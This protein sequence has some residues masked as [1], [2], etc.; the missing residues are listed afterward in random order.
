MS[1]ES[2]KHKPEV[3]HDLA[4]PDR[5]KAVLDGAILGNQGLWG[6]LV[7]PLYQDAPKWLQWLVYGLIIPSQLVV[8]GWLVYKTNHLS[9]VTVESYQPATEGRHQVYALNIPTNVKFAGEAVPL[10]DISVF[11]RFD[12]ELTLNIYWQAN[13]AL[14]IKRC[15]RWFPIITPIIRSQGV[16]ED[17][18][19]VAAIESMFENR[20]SPAG[21]GG[22]WQLMGSAANQYGLE[23]NREVDERF[24]LQKA[25]VAAC[26]YIK[27]ARRTLGSWS[28]ALASYNLGMGRI[29]RTM[30]RQQKESYYDLL[31]NAESS[32]YVFKVLA[33]KQIYLNQD[34][35]S[36]FI[37]RSE[38]LSPY[39]LKYVK[40]TS[41]IPDLSQWA[42]SKGINFEILKFYNPWLRANSLTVNGGKSYSI[43]LPK[44]PVSFKSDLFEPPVML[45]DSLQSDSSASDRL[46]EDDPNLLDATPVI[47]KEQ[48]ATPKHQEKPE[49][50]E[51]EFMAQQ[52]GA[53]LSKSNQENTS[54]TSADVVYH[55]VKS[56]DNPTRI[57]HKYGMKLKEFIALN[58]DLNL[59]K[60]LRLK[61]QVRVK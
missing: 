55:T 59:K 31:V 16:P 30:A 46:R 21:A 36:F 2:D 3:A 33:F 47:A 19:Y 48:K 53:Y 51:T 25:T 17:F 8:I 50:L 20:I 56:G 37:R 34:E 60:P 24:N 7:R 22:V 11:N 1:N 9:Q 54:E 32:R 39:R 26:K 45:S 27:T 61:Q 58:P 4:S 49:E 15:A 40:V 35:Y 38:L 44:D 28:A 12:R 6:K 43:A 41:S 29:Q 57:A 5:K 10:K 14:L 23:I 42:R 13:T 18:K 52:L